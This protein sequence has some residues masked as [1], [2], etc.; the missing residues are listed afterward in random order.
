MNLSVYG[1]LNFS[2]APYR[3]VIQ[4]KYMGSGV[5]Y[6]TVMNENHNP[7]EMHSPGTV[8]TAALVVTLATV[9]LALALL[10]P[11]TAV[12]AGAVVLVATSARRFATLRRRRRE[13]RR[14]Q[15]VCVPATD[16]CVHI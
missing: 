6:P 13:A 10:A 1:E 15:Q 7:V 4:L 16:V 12:A 2:N 8:V 3:N 5:H 14:S 9:G 11:T